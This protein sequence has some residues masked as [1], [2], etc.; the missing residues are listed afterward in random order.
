M[1]A[2]AVVAIECRLSEARAADSTVERPTSSDRH[3]VMSCVTSSII[4]IRSGIETASKLAKTPRI[5]ARVV[6]SCPRPTR[7]AAAQL[8]NSCAPSGTGFKTGNGPFLGNMGFRLKSSSSAI[9]SDPANS[10]RDN[11][12]SRRALYRSWLSLRKMNHVP[13]SAAPAPTRVAKNVPTKSVHG[14]FPLTDS[15]ISRSQYHSSSAASFTHRTLS[16]VVA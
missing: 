8:V 11:A 5:A 13:A 15:A 3:M 7:R 9:T 6:K 2:Y 1:S 4:A 10:T 16:V 12:S 14:L